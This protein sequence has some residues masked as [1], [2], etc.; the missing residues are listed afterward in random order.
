VR[1][2]ELVRSDGRRICCGPDEQAE[3]FRATIGGLGLTGLILW[4]EIQL[5]P[6][7]GP[8]MQT[9]VVRFAHLGEF[10]PLAAASDESHEYTVAWVDCLARGK[11]LG[12]GV[13]IRGNHSDTPAG[14]A[15]SR[16]SLV[17][18]AALPM[19]V[20]SRPVVR[21]FNAAYFHGH[22]RT[23]VRAL[24][25]FDPFFYP[26]DAV[27]HWNRL[28]GPRGFLQY[29]CVVPEDDGAAAL[30]ELFRCA[31]A[32]GEASF[33]AV[34]KLF[35]AVASPGILSFPRPGYTLAM[36]FPVRGP[37]T[38]R[39]LDALDRI[40][41]DARGAVYP[42]KDA[43]MSPETFARGFPGVADFLRH[44]DPGFSSTLW[45]RVTG[46]GVP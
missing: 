35:G 38:F 23:P 8:F 5:R 40:V 28:Y 44:R 43:H 13:F 18:P 17:V 3:F 36:D 4:A 42:A 22:R 25:H 10:M 14:R 7:A 19:G 11:S 41:R 20:V 1:C 33:L 24:T 34:L 46:E 12:R 15:P 6:V 29:Q 16:R 21:A 39:L 27:R 26:L 30:A 32:S 31:G 2:L 37:R 45:R 9:E